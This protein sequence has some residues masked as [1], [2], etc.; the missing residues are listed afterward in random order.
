MSGLKNIEICDFGNFGFYLYFDY[1]KMKREKKEKNPKKSEWEIEIEVKIE[2]KKEIYDLKKINYL[3]YYNIDDKKSKELESTFK[4][5]KLKIDINNI[6]AKIQRDGKFYTI[7]KKSLSIYDNK[8]FFNKIYEINFKKFK[9]K[10]EIKSVILLDNND[11]VFHSI[12]ED[13]KRRDKLMIYRLK[14]GKYFLFQKINENNTGY[15]RQIQRS[16]C[17]IFGTKKYEVCYLQEISG[18]RFFC[19][20]NYGLKLYSL[21]KKSK[22]SIVLLELDCGSLIH[23]INENNFLF[24]SENHSYGNLY[25]KITKISLRELTKIEK[26]KLKEKNYYDD[27]FKKIDKKK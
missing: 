27:D 7:S 3:K 14:D 22:Y 24:Y 4:Q 23:E 1:W 12:V 26:E 20:S 2:I 8:I 10:Y 15:K 9:K 5:I 18:N 13:E 11:L 16:E 6:Y 17:L 25:I 21:N 19:F